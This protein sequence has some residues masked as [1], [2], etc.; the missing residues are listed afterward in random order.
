M[1]MLACAALFAC[2]TATAQTVPST[3]AGPRA[4]MVR[5]PAGSYLP[6]YGAPVSSGVRSRSRVTVASFDMDAHAVTNAEYLQFVV[7]HPEWRLPVGSERE[8]RQWVR[9]FDLAMA[10]KL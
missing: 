6:L 1:R 5:L 2:A 4:G 8:A 9:I 10:Q 3:R 7:A